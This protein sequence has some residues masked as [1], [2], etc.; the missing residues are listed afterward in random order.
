MKIQDNQ[1]SGDLFKSFSDPEMAAKLSDALKVY[2]GRPVRIMEVC[3]THTMSVFRYGIRDILPPNITLV[4]GPGC[5]VCVTSASYIDAAAGLAG[6][7]DVI[8]T[9]FG[10]LMRI[11]GTEEKGK[12]SVSKSLNAMKSCGADV[13][14]VYSPLDS[15]QIAEEN[16]DKKVVFLSVGFETTAPVSALAVMKAAERGGRQANGGRRRCSRRCSYPRTA[17]RR[18]TRPS[19]S[20]R[21]CW[22]ILPV[23]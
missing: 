4:S 12:T 3:G 9:T 10:D 6:R 20:R 19:P 15:L 14:I 18:R 7:E 8:I 5:P 13:R 17:R 22:E 23:R 2:K 16:P 1:N 11:P 21:S